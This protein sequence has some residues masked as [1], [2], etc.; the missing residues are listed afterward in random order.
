MKELKEP[1]KSS[2]ANN[3]CLGCAGL[4]EEDWKEPDRCPYAPTVEKSI[5]QIKLNLGMEK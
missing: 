3:K 5:E 4:A 1:C 2:I